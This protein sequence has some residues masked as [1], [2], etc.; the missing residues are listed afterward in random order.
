[1][2]IAIYES[3][4]LY[5]YWSLRFIKNFNRYSYNLNNKLIIYKYSHIIRKTYAHILNSFSFILNRFLL[6]FA[7]LFI[8]Y[9]H[10]VYKTLEISIIIF[11]EM[12]WV[13]L[14]ILH[15]FVYP[16]ALFFSLS[17]FSIFLCLYINCSSIFSSTHMLKTI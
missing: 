10:L 6:I 7:L 4:L 3:I 14:F 11:I 17:Y 9:R 2:M 13:M 16:V 15:N 1:M 12:F 5:I 8:A